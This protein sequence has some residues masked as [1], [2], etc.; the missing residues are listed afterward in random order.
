MLQARV[1]HTLS[2]RRDVTNSNST[3]GFQRLSLAVTAA[4]D[5]PLAMDNGANVAASEYT[6]PRLLPL[7]MDNFDPTALPFPRPSLLIMS[8]Y[9][10][11]V[12]N[13]NVTWRLPRSRSTHGGIRQPT[14]GV[15]AKPDA[16]LEPH[17]VVKAWQRRRGYLSGGSSSSLFIVRLSRARTTP[18]SASRGGARARARAVERYVGAHEL[19]TRCSSRLNAAIALL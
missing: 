19:W 9:E 17:R 12:T 1:D 18:I 14:T 7:P 5:A 16:Q 8:L 13:S 4:S 15:G 11:D 3:N 10:E 2:Y 6:V